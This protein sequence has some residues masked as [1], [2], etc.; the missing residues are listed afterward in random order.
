MSCNTEQLEKPELEKVES[1]GIDYSVISNAYINTK[2]LNNKSLSKFGFHSQLET[3]MVDY[4]DSQFP[5]NDYKTIYGE[6]L[7]SQKIRNLS[8]VK[9]S[10]ARLNEIYDLHQNI[11]DLQLSEPA[12]TYLISLTYAFDSR[13]DD[14]QEIYVEQEAIDFIN[15]ELN[16]M[17][18]SIVND[19]S[20]PYS[21][22]QLLI[23]AI[24]A[25]SINIPFLLDEFSTYGS[26]NGRWLRKFLRQVVTVVVNV[27]VGVVTG[28][29]VSGGNP[30]GAIVGGVV[31]LG[32]GIYMIANNE[33]YAFN[34]CQSGRMSCE[35]GA[36]Y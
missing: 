21:E 18:S 34:K 11:H 7:T 20:I 16:V 29:A 23:E 6:L 25:Y 9:F 35:T 13:I 33:C 24:D 22:K 1:L 15:S 26:V 3:A 8:Y 10:N 28:L 12:E 30:I 4:L 27:A 19:P 2:E 32:V 14:L 5:E 17:K 36:C 31:G